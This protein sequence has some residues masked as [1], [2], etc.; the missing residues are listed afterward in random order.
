MRG[1]EVDAGQQMTNEVKISV[2][3]LGYRLLD[4]LL[5]AVMLPGDSYEL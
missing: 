2:Y 1:R 4:G 5:P 3:M